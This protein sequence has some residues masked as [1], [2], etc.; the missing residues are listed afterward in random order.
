[1]TK[2]ILKCVNTLLTLTI[3][4]AKGRPLQTKEQQEQQWLLTWYWG[5]ILKAVMLDAGID[6]RKL[7]QLAQTTASAISRLRNGSLSQQ[8]YIR[9]I[10]CLPVDFRREYL[11]K[12]FFG[13]LPDVLPAD[14]RENFEKKQRSK[15]KQRDRYQRK[16]VASSSD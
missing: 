7:A 14:V 12:V 16:L 13:D 11:E 9:V 15:R 10:R 6:G 4:A 5:K 8:N 3:V 2:I 1:M